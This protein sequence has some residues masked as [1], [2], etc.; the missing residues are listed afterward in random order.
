MVDAVLV[1]ATALA[2]AAV[3]EEPTAPGVPT[4][5]T[6]PSTADPS[7][8]PAPTSPPTSSPAPTQPQEEGSDLSV[9]ASV[10]GRAFLLRERI[11]ITITIRNEGPGDATAV[12]AHHRTLSGSRLR[13]DPWEWRD[14][15]P[16][17]EGGGLAAGEERIMEVAGEVWEWTGAGPVVRLEVS[18]TNDRRAENNSAEVPIRLVSPE[19]TKAPVSG[20]VFGDRNHN[21]APD[22]G[23]GL[24]GVRVDLH[25]GTA[26]EHGITGPDGRFLFAD[27]PAG[28]NHLVLSDAPGGWIVPYGADGTVDGTDR[29]ENIL[30]RG[31]RPL[32]ETLRAEARFTEPTYAPG[33]TATLTVTLTNTGDRPLS[34]I[35][36][37]CDPSGEGPH[38]RGTDDPA[39][40]G[41]L[42]WG[43]GV[44]LTP[45]QTRA[46]TVTGVVPDHAIDHGVVFV[47]CNVG[48]D[49]TYVRG[50]PVMEAEA[51]VPGL[52]GDTHG[53]LLRDRGLETPGEPIPN[54]E[55]RLLDRATGEVVATTV[56]D[57]EGRLGYTDIPAGRYTPHII[58]PWKVVDEK[59]FVPVILGKHPRPGWTIHVE[60]GPDPR[61]PD[62][63]APT[64]PADS[65]GTPPRSPAGGAGSGL[66]DTGLD[67]AAPLGTGVGLLAA[68]A[69]LALL[70]RR[71]RTT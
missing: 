6:T 24:A 67:L 25:R 16:S 51:K 10:P 27:V 49:P 60:P 15:D 13:I 8:S 66:A 61:D 65:A 4:A 68:G 56:S 14:F 62:A 54:T 52:R 5:P 47:T 30:V 53:W 12:K 26:Y 38:L 55:V 3:A 59:S 41:E 23:E 70:A 22:P 11:P 20:L 44:S 21:G 33:T 34:G 35:V 58:G 42:A 37:A 40:W 50:F 31:E 9:T 43:G 2:P 39:R 45:G 19:E 18:A 29:S 63:P 1:D 48:D 36:A 64:P 32:R 71:A 28:V 17:G 57:A 69:A 46:F 7:M